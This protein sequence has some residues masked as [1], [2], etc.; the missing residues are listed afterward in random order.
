VSGTEIEQSYPY[1]SARLSTA[2]AMNVNRVQPAQAREELRATLDAFIRS[3][4][5]GPELQQSLRE[6]MRK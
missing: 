4:V 1:W 2:V 5:P 3:G 6:E